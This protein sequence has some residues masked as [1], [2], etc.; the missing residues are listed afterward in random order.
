MKQKSP[1]VFR[2]DLLQRYRLIEIVA[3]WE[4]K[5]NAGHLTQYFGIGRQQASKDINEYLSKVGPD[6]LVYNSSLKGY[7]P[8]ANFT[9][10]VTSG[11]ADEYLQLIHRNSDLLNTF[12]DMTLGFD[13]THKM[14][15]PKY[16]IRPVVLRQIVRACR[17]KQ[18]LEV[19]YRS[20]NT[21][22]KDGR[23]IV[24]HS[25]VHS[26]MRWHV[27]AFCE[28]NN[29]YRDFVLTRFYGTPEP[30]GISKHTI[31]Q[32]ESW[33]SIVNVCLTPDQRLSL[34]QQEIVA[35]DYGMSDNRLLIQVRGALVQYLLQM[36]RIDM[37]VIAADPRAQQVVIQ[38]M[39][40]V[41]Q[42]LFR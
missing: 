33:N 13:Y 14:P 31:G 36:M 29:D 26:G 2:Y 20:V 24:P 9:P 30:M 8:S 1:W 7:E 3:L 41:K 6:N 27:R 12:E 37:N 4:G 22:D 18:R 28:K 34:E 16:R 11:D 23:I 42:W 17:D 38:N 32:D 21:P 5:L 19:D 35:N 25:I 15:L 39:D 10:K 40:A